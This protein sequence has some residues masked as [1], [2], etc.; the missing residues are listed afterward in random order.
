MWGRPTGINPGTRTT[1]P[2]MSRPMP[3]RGDPLWDGLVFAC[4]YGWRRGYTDRGAGDFGDRD[5]VTR[6]KG[7]WTLGAG[8]LQYGG[9][10]L[11]GAPAGWGCDNGDGVTGDS[12]QEW[13]PALASP[14]YDLPAQNWTVA[15]SIR[16]DVVTVDPTFPF[17]KRRAQPYGGGQPGWHFCGGVGGVWRFEWAGGGVEQGMSFNTVQDANLLRCDFLVVQ[18]DANG[19][20]TLATGYVNGNRDP[21]SNSVV[22]L[23]NAATTEAVKIFGLGPA[24]ERFPG[25]SDVGYVWERTLTVQ[26][27]MRLSAD[28]FAPFRPM[29]RLRRRGLG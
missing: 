17:F 14:Y 23:A 15:V 6:Y 24:N 5:E 12:A 13:Q 4:A 16:A 22:Q 3:H 1:R 21:Q 7:F 2:K 8:N 11:I 18:A 27:I 9:G 19:A 28:R 10:V 25:F 20:N 29:G 26:E